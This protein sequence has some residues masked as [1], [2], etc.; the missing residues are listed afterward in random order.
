MLPTLLL[1]LYCLGGQSEG[2]QSDAGSPHLWPPDRRYL[3]FSPRLFPSHPQLWNT[4]TSPVHKPL[5]VLLL[6]PHAPVQPTRTPELLSIQQWSKSLP[7]KSQQWVTPLEVNQR[8]NHPPKSSNAGVP[9]DVIKLPVVESDK[10]KSLEARSKNPSTP[11]KSSLG[12]TYWERGPKDKATAERYCFL[13]LPSFVVL[14]N[15]NPGA[16]L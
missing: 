8:R 5:P 2:I 12:R 9:P 14:I 11:D 6:M 3:A 13:T 16:L 4:T 7:H 1:P 15:G 10:P